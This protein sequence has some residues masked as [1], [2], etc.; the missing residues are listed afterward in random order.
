MAKQSIETL[1]GW[2]VTLAK[3]VQSQ[4][5]DWL[6]S[7][8]HRDDKI[9]TADLDPALLNLITSLPTADAIAALTTAMA[10]KADLVNGVLKQEQWPPIITPTEITLNADSSH[11]MTVASLLEKIIVIPTDTIMFG[12]GNAA[13]D[14]SIWPPMELTAGQAYIFS[15]ELYALDSR[16]IFFNGITAQTTIKIYNR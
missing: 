11:E 13:D 14:N 15:L 5:W 4:F 9:G 1:K 2:F 3:P 10:N 12:I 6:D 8:R 16:T 7:F